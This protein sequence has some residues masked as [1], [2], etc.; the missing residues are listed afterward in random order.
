MVTS[1]VLGGLGMVELAGW[2]AL[3]RLCA[4]KDQQCGALDSG[5]MADPLGYPVD[6]LERY[7]EEHG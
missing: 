1:L 2:S 4:S 6:A 7:S 3:G 5:G